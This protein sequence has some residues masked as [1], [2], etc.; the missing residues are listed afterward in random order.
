MRT[1]ALLLAFAL[2]CS[3]QDPAPSQKDADARVAALREALKGESADAKKQAVAACA[4]CAHPTVTAALAGV[5]TSGDDDLRVAAAQALSRMKGSGDAAKAL[6]AGL[7][8]NETREAVLKEVFKG[9]ALV[10][11]ASSVAV[12]RDW[13]DDRLDMQK[14]E[15]HAGVIHAIDVLG[16]LK[17]KAAVEVLLDL[18]HKKK[19]S[20][21]GAGTGSAGFKI[22][23][24]AHAG[25]AL[26][27]L[28]GA[29]P[30]DSLEEWQDWWKEH[31]RE[32]REDM[33]AVK[34]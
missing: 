6:H 11:H 31:A 1:A 24:G 14:Y 32:Y 10:N 26:Q 13:I 16:F 21:W 15:E 4:D 8:P 9:I 12:C 2:A 19:V 23:C 25:A 28:T 17:H 29:G 34:K 7:K 33:S 20:G 3:A 5:L 30:Y 27:R 18:C 22:K